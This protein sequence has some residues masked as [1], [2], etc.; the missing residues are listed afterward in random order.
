M[1]VTMAVCLPSF[2]TLTISFFLPSQFWDYT[3]L[4]LSHR[5]IKSRPTE[6]ETRDQHWTQWRWSQAYFTTCS[7]NSQATLLCWQVQP[8]DNVSIWIF[9]WEGISS[10]VISM[11]HLSLVNELSTALLDCHYFWDNLYL[12][13]FFVLLRLCICPDEDSSNSSEMIDYG[14]SCSFLLVKYLV[15][16]ITTADRV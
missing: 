13:F 14:I 16:T 10:D 4:G 2:T 8:A 1:F 15:C 11:R 9:G 6:Y 5:Q 3:C 7:W 12:A